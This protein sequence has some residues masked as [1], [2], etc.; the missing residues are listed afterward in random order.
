MVII[1]K[2]SDL[3]IR[4]KEPKDDSTSDANQK[5]DAE[6]QVCKEVLIKSSPVFKS[7]LSS[8]FA[9]AT[10]NTVTLEGDPA[11]R[12]TS[13][14]I[15]FRLLHGTVTDDTYAVPLGEV[16][17][18]V[19]ACDKWDL[20]INNLEDWFAKW[21]GMQDV[22]KLKPRELLYPCW[23]LDHAK[24]F[25]TATRSLAYS[26]IGHITESN[27]TKHYQLHLPSRVIRKLTC[28]FSCMLPPHLT[29]SLQSSSMPPKAGFEQSFIAS[30][31][32]RMSSCSRHFALA[33]RKP[34]TAMRRLSGRSR[35]GRWSELPKN[36]RWEQSWNCWINSRTNRR[37]MPAAAVIAITKHL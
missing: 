6:F 19:A 18:L 7:M 37:R 20:E 27:P 13:M 31:S 23:R 24:G 33:K 8:H 29:L 2:L 1:T 10:Q 12:P 25:A 3:T 21:Y 36:S 34:C 35:S 11:T 22:K 14:G 16:W 30:S 26:N 4:V 28:T 15:L 9:E 32:N 17:N 5:P